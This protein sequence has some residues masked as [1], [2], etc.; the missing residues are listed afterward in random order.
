MDGSWTLT[1]GCQGLSKVVLPI[2]SAVLDMVSTTKKM[3]EGCYSAETL[4]MPSD[5]CF[6][7]FRAASVAYGGSQVRGPIG[8]TAAD[9]HHSHSHIRSE[10]RL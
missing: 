2:G 10:P 3:Q 4:Q 6:L 1:V 5:F 9:L 8:A 7:P